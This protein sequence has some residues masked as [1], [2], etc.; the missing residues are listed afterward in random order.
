[1]CL[2]SVLA[3]R[4]LVRACTTLDPAAIVTMSIIG[5]YIVFRVLIFG[6]E[7][8]SC[9]SG[10]LSTSE[11]LDYSMQVRRREFALLPTEGVERYGRV[12]EEVLSRY[13]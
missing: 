9:M 5:F 1:M 2:R 7:Y 8:T 11:R 6:S 4:S 3:V 13:R 10:L 12:V